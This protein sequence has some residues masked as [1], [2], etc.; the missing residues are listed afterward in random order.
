MAF[1]VF[2]LG[3]R[4]EERRNL[5]IVREYL[6]ICYR[7]KKHNKKLFSRSISIKL[8]FTWVNAVEVGRVLVALPDFKSGVSG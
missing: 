3:V 2:F 1:V 8:N 6:L 5:V 7:K 4:V